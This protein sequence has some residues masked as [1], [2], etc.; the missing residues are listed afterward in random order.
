MSTVQKICV[1]DHLG[2]SDF[3]RLHTRARRKTWYE[4][5]DLVVYCVFDVL[6]ATQNDLRTATLEKR[7]AVLAKILRSHSGR[8]LHVAGVEDGLWLY[9]SALGLKLEGVVGKRLGSTY[10]D[11]KQSADW[12]KVNRPGAVPPKRFEL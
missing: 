6:V 12:I 4:G 7:K 9:R 5:A 10:Q 2:R 11:G 3:N 1:L 8:V